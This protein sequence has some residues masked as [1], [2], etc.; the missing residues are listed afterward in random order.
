MLDYGII[1]NCIT[2]ALVKRDA[3]IDWMCFPHFDSPS[4]FARI[5]DSNKGGTM[6]LRPVG[7]YRAEQRYIPG[8]AILETKFK[9]SRGS[10][11]VYDFF[12]RYNRLLKGRKRKLVKENR[13]IRIIR[14]LT[15]RPRVRV[16]YDPRPD[17]AV[18]KPGLEQAGDGIACTNG[19]REIMLYSNIPSQSILSGEPVELNYTKY[20]VMG[21][22][23]REGFTV[24]KCAKLMSDTRKYWERW[25]STLMLPEANREFILRSAITLKLLTYSETGAIIAASTTS[26][27]EESGEERNWDYRY[28]W[29]RDA[30]LCADALKKVGR[31]YEPK[32]LMEFIMKR[33]LSDD[34]VQPLYGI[35]GETRITE[36]ELDHLAG[37]QNSRPVRVG[38]AAYRQRQW[39]I[40]G[41][42][43]DIVYLYFVYY[44][45]EK[46]MTKRQWRFVRYIVNQIK[47]N[48]DRKDS[49]IWEY[50]GLRDHYTYSKLMCYIGVDRAIKIAQH[51]GR[52]ELINE[53]LELKEEIREDIMKNA[54]DPDKRAFTMSYSNRSLDA[55]LL[56]MAYHEF[57]PR[58]DPRLI[59]TVR[60]IYEGLRKD[61]KVKRYDMEDDFGASKNAF[62]ICTFW[63]IDALYY[64]GEEDKARMLFSRIQKRSNHLGLFSEDLDLATGRMLGNFPQA[65]THIAMINSAI[66]LSEWSSKRKKID[67]SMVAEKRR[68]F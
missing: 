11:A 56:Q 20:L 37:Y 60:A 45:F 8:T 63:L 44:E 59:S 33:V 39:D 36:R 28:C 58:D 57:L 50:R 61:D 7:K 27:P 21:N 40:Y 1:G 67:W 17:Y 68:W 42:I 54:Y 48:W 51:F 49:S 23:S 31:D 18:E 66:L 64:I 3:S 24:K 6:R 47:F 12:P 16:E 15:G 30:A 43:I 53:W 29:I 5:L 62:T 19:G 14:P 38:N 41:E 35:N 46:R 34:H 10:F 13:L 32:K 55:S 26:I 25:C 4:V 2:C 22:S 65:Y 9:G 52:E